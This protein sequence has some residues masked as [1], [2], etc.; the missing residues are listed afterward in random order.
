MYSNL[1]NYLFLIVFIVPD[2]KCII[3][4]YYIIFFYFNTFIIYLFITDFLLLDPFY[5]FIMFN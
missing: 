4:L 1:I 3:K 2:I 5:Y